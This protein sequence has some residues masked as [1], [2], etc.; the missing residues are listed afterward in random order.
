MVAC[1]WCNL[2]VSSSWETILR[3]KCQKNSFPPEPRSKGATRTEK[4]ENP[5]TAYYLP[6]MRHAFNIS[7]YKNSN[8]NHTEVEYNV[9]SVIAPNATYKTVPNVTGSYIAEL[10]IVSNCAPSAV[11][12]STTE[13]HRKGKWKTKLV[14]TAFGLCFM[15][16]CRCCCCCCRNYEN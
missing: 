15:H 16:R 11:T 5:P 7:C 8:R 13:T 14:L 2:V 10:H 1:S 9:C 3:A 12:T 4:R 6:I